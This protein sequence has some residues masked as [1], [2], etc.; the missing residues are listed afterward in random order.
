M[1]DQ[2]L[3]DAL[4]PNGFETFFHKKDE[5]LFFDASNEGFPESKHLYFT[6]KETGERTNVK[7]YCLSWEK[8]YR[9]KTLA[10][11]ITTPKEVIHDY[12]YA[13]HTSPSV[14]EFCLY[15]GDHPM[16]RGSLNFLEEE[17]CTDHSVF[18]YGIVFP[19]GFVCPERQNIHLSVG[20]RWHDGS[21]IEA[22]EVCLLA[23]EVVE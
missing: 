21:K 20:K 16:F 13:Y 7:Q 4:F 23:E 10:C 5:D 3:L 1:I 11:Q 22:L 6:S 15:I 2:K 18:A 14:L 19:R 8:S 17:E 12:R 9:I